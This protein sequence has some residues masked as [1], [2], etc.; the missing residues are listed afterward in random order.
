[1]AT[2]YDIKPAFQALLR[3]AVGRL[4]SAG[5][6]ANQVTVA[7]VILSLAA[8]L[9]V[10]LA[11]SSIWPFLLLPAVL[12]A[13]MALNAVDG[14]LAREHDMVSTLGLYLNEI[15]DVVSDLAVILPFALV[16]PF[17]PWG[18]VATTVNRVRA[19]VAAAR[20]ASAQGHNHAS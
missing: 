16:A 14:M 7:G 2:L 17:L 18:V 3:P 13:R 4:A 6:T 1:M 19:G 9:A 8:G 15:G 10:A 20:A 11:P 12:L 5:V